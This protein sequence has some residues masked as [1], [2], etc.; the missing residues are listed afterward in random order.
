MKSHSGFQPYEC[1]YQDCRK[2]FNY[3]YHLKRHMDTHTGERPF[4][5]TWPNCDQR[6]NRK[7]N[8][9]RHLWIHIEHK[10]KQTVTI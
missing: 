9:N 8:L 6:F 3:N 4:A 2:R 10:N 1:I 7:Y 5:C